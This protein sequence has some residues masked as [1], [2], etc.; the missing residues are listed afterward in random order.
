MDEPLSF[1]HSAEE[2]PL[3][4]NHSRSYNLIAI[5]AS[6]LPALP[7]N[8]ETALRLPQG[9][10][11]VNL[12]PVEN[13]CLVKRARSSELN[14]RGGS[15]DFLFSTPSRID[16]DP[17]RRPFSWLFRGVATGAKQK[18]RVDAALAS[19]KKSLPSSLL[20]RPR[21]VPSRRAQT[22]RAL[23]AAEMP[24]SP[25]CWQKPHCHGPGPEQLGFV[26]GAAGELTK[27]QVTG[28]PFVVSQV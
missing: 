13:P 5:S 9:S 1:L 6:G 17:D 4:G 7:A 23:Y 11:H 16:R 8:R 12:P 22:S 28:A 10:Y 14:L 18:S 19:S 27:R 24:N 26:P 20:H 25:R 3:E 2:S 15:S 21:R